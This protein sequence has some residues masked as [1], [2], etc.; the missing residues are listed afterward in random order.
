M[1]KGKK[2]ILQD[3][4]ELLKKID[5][6]GLVFLKDQAAVLVYNQEVRKQ[7]DETIKKQKAD[8]P[9]QNRVQK[10]KR[11]RTDNDPYL[12]FNVTIEQVKKGKNFILC[13]HKAR[14][15]MDVDEIKALFH[16][17]DKAGNSKT[18]APRLY[19]WLQKERK[20]VLID[21]KI[22]SH[23]SPVLNTIYQE[24]IDSFTNP[25]NS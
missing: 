10:V 8:I 14:L 1:D 22:S 11:S 20:D 3:I 4:Q 2:Q 18:A 24:L 23:M 25:G 7:N 17:A 21:G 6:D 9:D 19:R 15:F 16:I 12:S 5:Q 13:I